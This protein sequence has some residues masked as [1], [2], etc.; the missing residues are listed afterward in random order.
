[1]PA[2]ALVAGLIAAA[3]ALPAPGSAAAQAAPRAATKT[4]AAP[5]VD[6]PKI[7]YTRFTLANGL[8]VILH[9]DHSSPIA[10][11]EL[12]YR[13]GSKDDTP[14]KTGLAHLFEHM[15]DEGSLHVPKGDHR[16]IIQETGG[17]YNASTNEDRTNYFSKV[18]SNQLE[19]VLWLEA[20]RMAFL[21][22]ALD[23]NTFNIEREQVRNEYREKVL[24]QNAGGNLGGEAFFGAMFAG[25]VYGNPLYGH[26]SEL[27]A[28]TMDDLRA[29]YAKYY[30]PN[31]AALAIAGDFDSA[32]I[33]KKV[34]RYFG[35]IPR[36]AAVRRPTGP[37]PPLT[38][39]KRIVLEDKIAPTQHLWIGW[40]GVS[41]SNPDRMA[42][43]ALAGVLNARLQRLLVTERRL[44]T[45][46]SGLTGHYDLEL[47]GLFQL[48]IVATK[49]SMMTAIERLTD[50]VVASA[51]NDG[52][53]ALELKRWVAPFVTASLAQ[54]QADS[55]K[56][57]KLADGA[58]MQGSPGAWFNDVVLARKLT[59]ADLQRV[60]RKYLGAQRVVMS[61]VP[62]GKLEL[63]S[64]PTE[65]YVNVTRK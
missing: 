28:A 57:N 56:A 58:M 48:S 35:G 47:S 29:Y 13:V 21:A 52:V 7:G 60:A 44:A 55:L 12:W 14:G 38:A 6:V 25:T 54:M 43:T 22:P 24:S 53:T 5:A 42:L 31:N 59:P 27:G 15:L 37:T 46:M 10:A 16:R 50:S 61:I 36:G 51:R 33:R 62:A 23:S 34:E 65:P 45:T 32:D 8:Q 2:R 3:A 4:A 40:R 20:E 11:V 19:T 39:E 1:M 41:S 17:R 63:I 18:P 26:M 64:K 9:E 30:V 49:D